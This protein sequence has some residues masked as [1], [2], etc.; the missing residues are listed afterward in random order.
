[1]SR[2]DKW[3]KD[4]TLNRVFLD[5]C[6]GCRELLATEDN[7]G[8]EVFASVILPERVTKDSIQANQTLKKIYR[9]IQQIFDKGLLCWGY[10]GFKWK[11]WTFLLDEV[12]K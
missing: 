7:A 8:P 1:M 12:K 3:R 5:P 9:L 10:Q 6:R 4:T 11:A 2:A